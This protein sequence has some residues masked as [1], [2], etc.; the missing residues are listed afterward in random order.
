MLVQRLSEY[1]KTSGK[2]KQSVMIVKS[3]RE[4]PYLIAG[5]IKVRVTSKESTV[6]QKSWIVIGNLVADD[7]K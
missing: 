6:S 3:W 1:L 4:C 2:E 5:E 7:L